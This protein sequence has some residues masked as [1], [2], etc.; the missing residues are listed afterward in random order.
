MKKEIRFRYDCKVLLILEDTTHE[1]PGCFS[2]LLHQPTVSYWRVKCFSSIFFLNGRY[3]W[4]EPNDILSRAARLG[5]FNIDFKGREVRSGTSISSGLRGRTT[6]YFKGRA[7]RL[8]I[9]WVS[10]TISNWSASTLYNK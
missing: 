7:V 4:H 6:I 5:T 8:A 2:Y 1:T 9:C 3:R 10:S